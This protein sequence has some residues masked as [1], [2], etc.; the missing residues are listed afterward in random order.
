LT[1]ADIAD[2]AFTGAEPFATPGSL[3][4]LRA[5]GSLYLEPLHVIVARDSAVRT[6]ADL[7][8]R[9]VNV[10]PV[11][12]GS[13]ITAL[14]VLAAH[15]VT[16]ERIRELG[17][18]GL[19]PALAALRDGRTD[20]VIEVIGVP[21]NEIRVAF[22]TL[23]LRLLPLEQDA[24]DRLLRDNRAYLPASILPEAYPNLVTRVPTIGVAAILA[25]TTDLTAAEAAAAT[26]IVFSATG[27]VEGGSPQGAQVNLRTARTGVTIPM[28]EGAERALAELRSR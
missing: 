10:G 11:T 5:L 8:G 24:V 18:L 1:Q 9:R 19:T 3:A 26:R 22:A 6:I 2:L 17:E 21:A 7:A 14:N 27:L 25:T 28:H 15:G 16:P 20:A 13:R 23:P 4:N 12:S